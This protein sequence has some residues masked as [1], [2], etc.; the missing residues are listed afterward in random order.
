M[1]MTGCEELNNIRKK[2]VESLGDKSAQY[3]QLMKLWF[4][5]KSR[6]EEFDAES[7]KLMTEDQV[8]LHNT[9][10]LCLFNK[11]HALSISHNSSRSQS[12]VGNRSSKSEDKNKKTKF[13]RRNRSDKGFEP[14]DVTEYLPKLNPLPPHALEE[15][16]RYCVQEFFLPD[17]S[18]IFGR[19]LLSAWEWG[20]EGAEEAVG[21]YLVVA[22]QHLLKNVLTAILSRKNGYKV[23]EGRFIYGMGTA[24]PNPWLRSTVRALNF[25]A[26]GSIG[27]DE[28]ESESEEND[29]PLKK[30]TLEDVEQQAAYEIAC[31]SS[32]VVKTSLT[33]YHVLEA[34]Q[35]H[36]N[37][38]PANNVYSLFV[39]RVIDRLY[40]PS[41]EEIEAE[42]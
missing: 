16:Q 3:F 1:R 8:H 19:L 7:R 2:L 28:E 42:A 17:S 24:I 14:V 38:I 21:D 33:P 37:V 30:P 12:S 40:H 29:E 9:F 26:K 23:R 35:V 25:N 22:V 34:L 11:C 18:L 4:Q 32:N 10:L 41:H 27:G 5:M 15:P 36:R 31:S 20:L 13:K 39:Q 6:K